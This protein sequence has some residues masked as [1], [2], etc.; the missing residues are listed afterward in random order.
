LG[1]VE[2]GVS[3]GCCGCWRVGGRG[4]GDAGVACVVRPSGCGVIFEFL[5]CR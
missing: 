2:E 5:F 1:D 3:G 4:G